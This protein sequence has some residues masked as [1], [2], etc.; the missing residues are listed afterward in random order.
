MYP[1]IHVV[2][3]MATVQLLWDQKFHNDELLAQ[4]RAIIEQLK[5]ENQ[6]LKVFDAQNIQVKVE[7]E[8]KN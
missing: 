8:E 6:Q 4:A 3:M 1:L 2:T 7:K 5:A